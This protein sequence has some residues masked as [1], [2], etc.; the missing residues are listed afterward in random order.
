MLKVKQKPRILGCEECNA[1]VSSAD[2]L[3]APNTWG[4]D[5]DIIGCPECL[6]PNTLSLFVTSP[7]GHQ[8]KCSEHRKK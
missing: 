6:A 1:I 8:N 4:A 5:C 2:M 3:K 7:Y